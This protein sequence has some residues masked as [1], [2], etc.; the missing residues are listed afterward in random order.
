MKATEVND[1]AW[2]LFPMTW[3]NNRGALKTPNG[4]ITYGI[5]DPPRRG[6]DKLKGGDRIGWK[7]ITITPEMVGKK[8]AVFTSIEVKATGDT[9]A[10]GQLDWH[11]LVINSGGI[12]EIWKADKHDNI[13]IIREVIK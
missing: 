12:S 5:P 11:N 2:L 8:I 9:L 1:R 6:E 10:D 4:F 3:R 13:E 7:E